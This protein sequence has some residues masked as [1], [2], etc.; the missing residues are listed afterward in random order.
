LCG[1]AS[2]F[3]V[4]L[5]SAPKGCRIFDDEITERGQEE[6]SFLIRFA[7]SGGIV[8]KKSFL[9]AHPAPT[10]QVAAGP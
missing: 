8:L 1:H 9:S 7:K 4:L 6:K 2:P 5:Q 3:A 10:S